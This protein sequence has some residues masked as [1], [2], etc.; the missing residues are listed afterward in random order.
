MDTSNFA[1]IELAET[2]CYRAL[3]NTIGDG[4][5]VLTEADFQNSMDPP[6]P[7]KLLTLVGYGQYRN[8]LTTKGILRGHK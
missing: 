3:V 5:V 4:A 6:E 1:I 8:D 2:D 7:L